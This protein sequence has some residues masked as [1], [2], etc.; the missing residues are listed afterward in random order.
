MSIADT[1]RIESKPEVC[2]GKP[3]IAGTRIRVQDIY[4]WHE[5]QG[6]SADAIVTRFPQLQMSD[7]YAALAYYWDNRSELQ[8]QMQEESDFVEQMKRQFPSLLRQQLGIADVGT[9]PLP[10]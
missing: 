6:Q 4:V 9:D 2:G 5:L 1:K 10:S 3:C 7:I 8:R